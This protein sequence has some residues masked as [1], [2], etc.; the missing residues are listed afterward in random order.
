[1]AR[2]EPAATSSRSSCAKRTWIS[3]RQLEL[4]A[5]Q[6]GIDLSRRRKK[7]RQRIFSAN[8]SSRPMKPRRHYY[9]PTLLLITRLRKPLAAI[10]S[11]AASTPQ[12]PKGSF[13][14]ALRLDNWSPPA[15][16]LAGQEVQPRPA[17][18]SG[19]GQ[20]ERGAQFSTYDMF[21]NRLIFP[22]RD[23]Q[24]RVIGF[25]GRVL[26]DSVPKYLNTV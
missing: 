21:R 6:A 20:T 22:I 14:W 4:L 13:A 2:A 5:R 3:A 15:R 19:R 25:G 24:G 1:L 23:R 7:H 16:C 26:D 18:G 12:P 8:A 9:E 10:C 17:A 11:A